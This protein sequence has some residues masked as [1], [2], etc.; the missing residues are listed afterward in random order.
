[1]RE[2]VDD[3]C[4]N[5]PVSGRVELSIDGNTA[6][7]EIL[8]FRGDVDDF[9]RRVWSGSHVGSVGA[10]FGE[11]FV[12]WFLI[13]KDQGPEAFIEARVN[14]DAVSFSRGDFRADG[15]PLVAYGIVGVARRSTRRRFKRRFYVR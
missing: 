10:Q 11:E 14:G 1:V 6:V 3:A 13:E 9:T 5:T 12:L 2:C 8:R 15:S 7:L 4:E